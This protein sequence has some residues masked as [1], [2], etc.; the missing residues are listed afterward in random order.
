MIFVV[1]F[2]LLEALQGEGCLLKWE[3]SRLC[4]KSIMSRSKV[5]P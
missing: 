2:E 5:N 1:K 3:I 4:M